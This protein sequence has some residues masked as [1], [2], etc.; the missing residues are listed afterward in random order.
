MKTKEKILWK[1]LDL[2]NEKGVDSVSSK[3][4][5]DEMGISYGNLCYHYPRK[6]DIV[7]QL[8]VKFQ[9]ELNNQFVEI[10]QK[11][12]EVE[13]MFE[14]LRKMLEIFYKY[15]FISLGFTS[16]VRRFPRI[17]KSALENFEQRK[18]VMRQIVDFLIAKGFVKFERI[19]GHYDN[20]VHLT[21][22]MLNAWISD[23]ETFYN[24]EQENKVDYY[25]EIFYSF[26][27]PHLTPSGVDVFEEYYSYGE[28]KL[29]MGG[30]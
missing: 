8:Y 29:P 19:E 21:Q 11:G 7:M 9:E 4:I 17:K 28:N 10:Q 24:G 15:K 25:L 30:L 16:I 18:L 6:D 20:I 14:S 13:M 12:F 27:R 22:I 3:Q 1:A 26:M 2:F 5:S 23:S